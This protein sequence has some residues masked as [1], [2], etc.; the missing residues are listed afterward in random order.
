[1]W[2]IPRHRDFWAASNCSELRPV[3]GSRVTPPATG[4]VSVGVL[5]SH[6]IVATTLGCQPTRAMVRRPHPQRRGLEKTPSG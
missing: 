6:D 4:P 3:V 5:L 2:W 1:M